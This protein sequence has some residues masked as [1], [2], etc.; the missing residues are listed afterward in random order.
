MDF[1]KIKSGTVLTFQT[2]NSSR[3]LYLVAK[4]YSV[5]KMDSIKIYTKMVHIFDSKG[6]YIV[7]DSFK[8]PYEFDPEEIDKK[9]TFTD[10]AT[11]NKI[12][13]VFEKNGKQVHKLP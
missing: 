1:S 9:L 11:I 5:T 13:E 4:R 10:Q 2:E 7:T 8:Q 3:I 6:N 12:N